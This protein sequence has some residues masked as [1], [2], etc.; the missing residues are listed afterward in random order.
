MESHLERLIDKSV[1]APFSAQDVVFARVRNDPDALFYGKNIHDAVPA[2]LTQNRDGYSRVEYARSRAAWAV[3][4]RLSVIFLKERSHAEE[5]DSRNIFEKH[6]VQDP[7]DM[8]C[9]IKEAARLYGASLVG[10]AEL[11]RR[12]LYTHRRDGS[13]VS[14]APQYKNAIVMATAMDTG[15]IRKSPT[16]AAAGAVGA[17]YSR[18]AF[19]ICCVA[20]FIQSLGYSAIPMA[21]ESA[22]SIPMAIQAGLGQL[23]RNGLLLTDRFGACVRLCKVVTDLPLQPDQPSEPALQEQ[24]K[25]CRIC[26]E[27]CEPRAISSEREPSLETV[28]KS[29]SKGI[30][31]W[32]VN[33][34]LCYGFWVKNGDDCSNCIARCPLT[35][36]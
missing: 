32:T 4:D 11:D 34:E 21:N 26:C 16:F 10:I 13:A 20:E 18:M 24:C 23:G 9:S 19:L 33:P 22:L 25:S 1:F 28:S 6:E 2:I 29:N 12:W 14:I 35:P 5:R 27:A 30:L 17:G 31:R 3:D 8:S 15:V 36:R 7:A